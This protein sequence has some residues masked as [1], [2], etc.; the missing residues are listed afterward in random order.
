MSEVKIKEGVYAV[1]WVLNED[2]GGGKSTQTVTPEHNDIPNRVKVQ[3][4]ES[5][6]EE[7]NIP[8]RLDGHLIKD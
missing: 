8:I 3:I 7:L 6:L 1:Y 5:L 2:K 4:V